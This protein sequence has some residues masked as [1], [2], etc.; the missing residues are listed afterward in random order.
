ME[1][2]NQKI[3]RLKLICLM[4]VN[5]ISNSDMIKTTS[6]KYYITNSVS[7]KHNKYFNKRPMSFEYF[8][9]WRYESGFT[10]D[11]PFIANKY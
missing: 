4:E 7:C 3:C 9:E 2:S 5:M 8:F 11:I 10:T 6:I 1:H